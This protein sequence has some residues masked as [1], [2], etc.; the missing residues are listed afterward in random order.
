MSF[1][2]LAISAPNL[3]T[4]DSPFMGVPLDSAM[5]AL[6]PD[7]ISRHDSSF[8]IGRFALDAE[9]T[10]LLARVPGEYVPNHVALLVYNH[11]KR[12]LY[13]KGNVAY[14]WGDAGDWEYK[15]SWLIRTKDNALHQLTDFTS[16]YEIEG[17]DAEL[18]GYKEETDYYLLDI[19]SDRTDTLSKDS[20][21]LLQTYGHLLRKPET[22]VP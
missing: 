8:A 22:Q 7:E 3:E 1:D 21:V 11:S 6:L 16:G 13:Y 9:N 4:G 17:A 2:T 20:T 10:A 12:K 15:D 18:N 19:R 5:I 14:T